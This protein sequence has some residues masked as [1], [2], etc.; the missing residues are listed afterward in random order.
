MSSTRACTTERR[1]GFTLVELMVVVVI[2]SI[3][4]AIAIPTFNQYIK[5]SRTTEASGFLAEIKA[6]QESYRFDFGMYCD[7]SQGRGP[8]D[9]YPRGA[10]GREPQRWYPAGV[11]PAA[12]VPAGWI[13]LGAMPPGGEG[14]FVY[15]S[16]A[17]GQRPQDTPAAAGFNTNRDYP[18]PA[19]DFWFITTAIGDLDADGTFMTYESYSHSKAIYSSVGDTWE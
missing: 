1:A 18:A 3:L 9:L 4:A 10:P 19:T 15:S 13:T 17:G 11:N 16:V 2:I 8:G 6:R 14:R 12:V 7:V 5:K